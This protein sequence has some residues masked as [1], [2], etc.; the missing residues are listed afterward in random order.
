[1]FTVAN[2]KEFR[3]I[4]DLVSAYYNTKEL[5]NTNWT[6][7]E[8]LK[9]SLRGKQILQINVIE[10]DTKKIRKINNGQGV[11]LQ[12][13]GKKDIEMEMYTK[14]LNRLFVGANRRDAFLMKKYNSYQR[15]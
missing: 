10:D 12:P 13:E 15:I 8:A 2:K 14:Y 5:K 3:R 6:Q 9:L 7:L 1:L 11:E 4:N